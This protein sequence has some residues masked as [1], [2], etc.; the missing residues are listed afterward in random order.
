MNPF[1]FRNMLSAQDIIDCDVKDCIA[2]E[3]R[4]DQALENFHR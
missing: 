2:I 4:I 1:E 3:N